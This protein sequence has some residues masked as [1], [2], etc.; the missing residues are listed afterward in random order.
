[1]PGLANLM[2]GETENPRGLIWGKK[3]MTVW[4]C[5]SE[6]LIQINDVAWH[7]WCLASSYFSSCVIRIAII[8]ILKFCSSIIRLHP[9][10]TRETVLHFC[11]ACL[12]TALF[13]DELCFQ[14]MILKWQNASSECSHCAAFLKQIQWTTQ[15]LLLPCFLCVIKSQSHDCSGYSELGQS[16]AQGEMPQWPPQMVSSVCTICVC[17][18]V[19]LR[20][21]ACICVNVKTLTS[22][23]LCRH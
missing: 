23:A 18:N 1:M 20:S 5:V 12:P 14:M 2:R 19:R 13:N 21:Y 15:A 6:V 7:I 22:S 8:R 9:C 3:N 16:W 10:C 11:S 17:T 4:K